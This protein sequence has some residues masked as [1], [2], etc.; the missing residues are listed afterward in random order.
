MEKRFS[1]AKAIQFGFYTLF[2]HFGFFI[3]LIFTHMGSIIG[4]CAVV[5]PL[6][7]LPFA[8]KILMISRILRAAG[9]AH[10]DVAKALVNQMGPEFSLDLVILAFVI[11]CFYRFLALGLTRIAFDFHDTDQSSMNRLFSCG[12]LVFKD[13]LATMVYWFMVVVGFMLLVI[14]GIYIAITFAF[15]H[16][17]IVDQ[18]AGIIESLRKSS[19]LTHG[20]KWELFALGLLLT[21][22]R[23]LGLSL[24][25]VTIFVILPVTTLI[26]VYVYRRLQ[27]SMPPVIQ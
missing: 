23:W 6:F 13:A 4:F 16:Q 2:E 12:R 9:L 21:S 15:Y 8:S 17:C 19:R 11:F 18:N 3:G 20:A 5:V 1:I 24:W 27:A 7:L 14:P 26:D 22:V 10:A 25:G